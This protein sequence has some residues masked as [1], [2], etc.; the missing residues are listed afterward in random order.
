MIRAVMPSRSVLPPRRLRFSLST[1]LAGFALAAL[2]AAAVAQET[3]TEQSLPDSAQV[4]FVN[5]VNMPLRLQ[6]DPPLTDAQQ[7]VMALPPAP[8][9]GMVVPP[10]P[11]PDDPVPTADP[12]DFEGVWYHAQNFIIRNQ[13]DIYGNLVPFSMEG[14][15]TLARRVNSKLA[16]MPF[17]NAAS[18]CLPPG[19]VWQG[20]IHMPFA[21][22]Q[23]EE[24]VE[25][26]FMN[27]RGRWHLAL[28]DA[29]LPTRESYMGRSLAH[30]DGDTLVVET[31]DFK[32]DL[33]LDG[34]G[35]PVSTQGRLVQRIRKVG[36]GEGRQILV[37]ETTIIDPVNYTAPWTLVR[38]F[39][40]QPNLIL[41]D[42]YNCEEQ[43]GDPNVSLDGGLIFEPAD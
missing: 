15:Q 26:I 30:W 23:R 9:G 18:L 2:S 20:D 27:Y 13:R 4:A 34:D 35:T 42:E 19:P 12:R 1:V 43:L 29:L 21:I 10:P 17:Q 11:G 14:A 36:Q 40:W 28:D 41:F 22:F 25:F 24:A 33:W 32:Q 6:P 37:I 31:S 39:N 5:A 38:S 7:I 3:G 8:I 16:G